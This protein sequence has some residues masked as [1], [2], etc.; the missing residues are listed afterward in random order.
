M[1]GNIIKIRRGEVEREIANLNDRVQT[2]KS[3][4]SELDIAEKVLNRLTGASGG[5][6]GEANQ[7]EASGFASESP[8]ERPTVRQMIMAS[9][10]DARDRGAPGL[11]PRQMR[12]FI[13]KVYG[14]DVGQQVNTNASRML[15]ELKE[16]EKDEKT[17]L[18]SLPSKEKPSDT[19]TVESPSEGLFRNPEAQGR[20]AGPGG[21][22]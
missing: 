1:D 17:G 13:S 16:I 18:F 2:L 12:D 3:E 21:G 22:T 19:T 15:H 11:A 20:E 10:M 5:S 4:L 8:Q 9:L 7:R 14:V 6:S